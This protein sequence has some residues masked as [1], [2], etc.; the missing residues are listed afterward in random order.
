[1]RVDFFVTVIAW[2]LFTILLCATNQ[3]VLYLLSAFF[4]LSH[5][6]YISKRFLSFR[7]ISLVISI[8]LCILR[9]NKILSM[10]HTYIQLYR[11]ENGRYR[12]THDQT[13]LIFLFINAAHI[14]TYVRIYRHWLHLDSVLHRRGKK[15]SKHLHKNVLHTHSDWPTRATVVFLHNNNNTIEYIYVGLL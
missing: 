12:S 14:Q 6:I 10:K 2:I 8:W 5:S 9:E 11:R 1:M 15:I 4:S 13:I 3:S 7:F